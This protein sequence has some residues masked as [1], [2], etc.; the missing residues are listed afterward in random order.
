MTVRL[1]SEIAYNEEGEIAYND[2]VVH[3]EVTFNEYTKPGGTGN[4][5]EGT[6]EE[7][8]VLVAAAKT[9]ANTAK[10]ASDTAV[11][12]SEEA[13]LSRDASQANAGSASASATSAQGD[14]DRAEAA[15]LRAEEAA[16]RAE[17]AGSGGGSSPGGGTLDE[18]TLQQINDL[19]D[20]AKNAA[21]SASD[22]ATSAAES[23]VNAD[24]SADRAELAANTAEESSSSAATSAE[25]ASESAGS[26]GEFISDHLEVS[27]RYSITEA[28]RQFLALQITEGSYSGLWRYLNANGGIN[29]YF[30]FLAVYESEGKCFSLRDRIT[31]CE[32]SLRLGLVVPFM[33][34][35]RY[36][37]R[38]RLMIGDKLFFVN[39]AGVT[40]E[41]IP[42]VSSTTVGQFVYTGSAVLEC[43]GNTGRQIPPSWSWFFVDVASDLRTPVAPDSTDSYPSL[44]FACI[45]EIAD[46][47]WLS[48]SS[49]IGDYSRWEVIKQVA[50]SN[51]LSQLNAEANLVNVFQGNTAPG[52]TDYALCFC[53]DNAEVYAGLRAL[54]TLAALAGDSSA[55]TEYTT[56]MQTIK[57]GLLAL[58]VP[59]QKRFLTYYN[60][61]DYPSEPSA[62]RFVQKD[63]FSVAPWRFGVL[64]TLAEQ[65]QY[66]LP[67]LDAIQSAYPDLFTANY[68]GIDTFAMSD[69]FAF[70]TKVTASQTAATTTLRRLQIRKSS[71][72]TILDITAAMSVASWGAI[73]LMGMGDFSRI[74]G[75]SVIEGEDITVPER[76][77]KHSQPTDGAQVVVDNINN[78]VVLF[79]DNDSVLSYLQ[80]K[81]VASTETIDG[82][83]LS[84]VAKNDITRVAFISDGAQ[85]SN[86]PSQLSSKG[87][88]DFVYNA[89]L[90]MWWHRELALESAAALTLLNDKVDQRLAELEARVAALE[91]KKNN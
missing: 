14:A 81:L 36:E 56:A 65:E 58:F 51:I 71:A 53:Q 32:K 60:E 12:A 80:L 57:A 67:V 19:V 79:I 77:T 40:G 39:I 87:S 43:L 84:I 46:A 37:A 6:L 63:R 4:I 27:T 22:S 9:A 69:F 64:N 91:S 86:A 62:A 1:H 52:N 35:C 44:W 82:A 18:E 23:A 83:R 15:A 49:G 7:L 16:D 68:G 70:V 85:I 59:E 45:A 21:T 47:A 61:V 11:A 66:G 26:I 54:R 89:T 24:A 13:A 76:N 42:D 29:W 34:G 50:E 3:A 38:Q 28:N 10:N 78:D 31:I 30:L 25:A 90:K 17:S 33:T 5:D 72:V 2:K 8:Q 73:P 41:S 88:I 20:D 48:E 55:V 74:N 75:R